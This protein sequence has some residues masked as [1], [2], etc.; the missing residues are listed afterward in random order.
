MRKGVNPK[1]SGLFFPLL[2][3]FFLVFAKSLSRFP[4]CPPRL[5]CGVDEK[6]GQTFSADG[7]SPW[8]ERMPKA[9]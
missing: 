7:Y 2:K 6:G 5:P 1:R 9:T 4:A 3:T 8:G